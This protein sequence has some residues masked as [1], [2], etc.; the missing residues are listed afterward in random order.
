[1]QLQERPPVEA[2]TATPTTATTTSG[3]TNGTEP[4]E[5]MSHGL[6]RLG[7]G[8]GRV[9][10]RLRLVIL[11]LWLIGLA[12]SIPF[13][14][15]IG[16]VLTGGGYTLS[17]SESAQEAQIAASVVHQSATEVLVVF[18]SS[19]T[20][21]S[22]ASYQSELSDFLS[23]AGKLSGLFE[24]RAGAS[25]GGRQD[26]LR[27]PDEQSARGNGRAGALQH[28][29]HPAH[30]RPRQGVYHRQPGDLPRVHQADPGADAERGG[31]GAAGRAGRAGNRLR[32]AHRRGDPAGAGARSRPDRAGAHLRHRDAAGDERLRAQRRLDH[33]A[34]HLD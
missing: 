6:Y 34:G 21:V 23:R 30:Q 25:R 12:V 11:A 33:R 10:Y 19:D 28:T 17:N 2:E 31:G 24:R 8:Y 32:L 5:L 29:I 14:A 18:Q 20:A 1:M 16:T 26:D 9:V 4:T 22:D 27:H 15:K 13:A 3:A 7:F